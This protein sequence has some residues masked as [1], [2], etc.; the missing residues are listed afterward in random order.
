[1]NDSMCRGLILLAG[2]LVAACGPHA[3]SAG[4][5][6]GDDELPTTTCDG[7]QARLDETPEFVGSCIGAL[8]SNG[9]QS[10]TEYTTRPQHP[11]VG[12]SCIEQLCL[13]KSGTRWTREKCLGFTHCIQQLSAD[14]MTA[15]VYFSNPATCPKQ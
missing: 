8:A 15:D 13:K 6:A 10:C 4:S 1:M 5:D 14:G 2:L 7:T 11:V 9:N 12:R 3:K